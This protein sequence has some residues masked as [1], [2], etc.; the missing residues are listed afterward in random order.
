MAWPIET[1]LCRPLQSLLAL[2]GKT[3]AFGKSFSPFCS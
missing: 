1:E 3:W 2:K